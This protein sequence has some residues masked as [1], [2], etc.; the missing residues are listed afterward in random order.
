MASVFQPGACPQ[1]PPAG[2]VYYG[3]SVNGFCLL[4]PDDFRIADEFFGVQFG[5]DVVGNI[6]GIY[7]PPL[8]S[9]PEPVSAN[10]SISIV[11]LA[12]RSL[13]QAVDRVVADQPI[14]SRTPAVVGGNPAEVVDGLPGRTGNTQIFVAHDESLYQLSFFP[15]DPAFAQA[16][17]D[18][19][20]LLEAVLGSITFIRRGAEILA[21]PA[22]A[23]PEAG[24]PDRSTSEGTVPTTATDFSPVQAQVAAAAINLRT[25]P[26]TIHATAGLY[27]E[28]ATMTVT[29]KAPGDEWVQVVGPDEQSGWMAALFLSGLDLS[30]LPVTEPAD[31]LVVTGKVVDEAGEAVDQI[32]VAVYRDTASGQ[33]RTDASSGADGQFYAYLPADSQGVWNVAVAGIGCASRVAGPNCEIPGR[34]DVAA[35]GLAVPQSEPVTF[36]YIAP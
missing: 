30:R 33:Q 32:N 25:G 18:M 12:G 28:G 31:G 24:A 6:V 34:F 10:V 21:A 7:G 23:A 11:E 2:Y 1:T 17:P 20:R 27:S 19:A 8:D 9:S 4:Y 15:V 36:V 5:Q 13:A 14:T 22:V 26:S 3:S 35:L 29:G 16:D